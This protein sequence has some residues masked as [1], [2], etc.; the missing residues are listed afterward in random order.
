MRRVY[1]ELVVKSREDLSK[2]IFGL[3]NATTLWAL[4]LLRPSP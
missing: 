1:A 2:V 4:F 3:S